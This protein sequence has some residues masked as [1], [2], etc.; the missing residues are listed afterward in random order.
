MS[1]ATLH[2]VLKQIDVVLEQ[3]LSPRDRGQ[4]LYARAT[5]RQHLIPWEETATQVKEASELLLEGG[6]TRG[7][8]GAITF[9]AGTTLAL[10][11]ID[12]SMELALRALALGGEESGSMEAPVACNL[13]SILRELGAFRAA[14]NLGRVSIEV[15]PQQ[16]AG[17][18]VVVWFNMAHTALEGLRHATKLTEVERISWFE[19]AKLAAEALRDLNHTDDQGLA[20]SQ[21]VQ[22]EVHLA[23]GDIVAARRCIDIA[24]TTVGDDVNFLDALIYLA[25]GVILRHEDQPAAALARFDQAYEGLAADYLPRVRALQQRSEVAEQLGQFDRA[26]A[27]SRLLAEMALNRQSESSGNLIDQLTR[28]ADLERAQVALVS[29][30][31][32]LIEQVRHDEVTGVA[33]RSWL[34][35]TFDRLSATDD[36]VTLLILDLDSFKSINDRFGHLV[37]DEVLR[38]VGQLLRTCVRADDVAG[39]FG[40]DEF[41]VVIEHAEPAR[42]RDLAE[43]IRTAVENFDWRSIHPELEVTTSV[44]VA[45]GAARDVRAVLERADRNMYA[46]KRLGRNQIHGD[47]VRIHGDGVGETDQAKMR[48]DHP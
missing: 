7:A 43:A 30:T 5:A 20:I 23:A 11:R 26:L 18:N 28:R 45:S 13:G 35:V 46:A 38:H 8:L 15:D 33:S 44:G 29:E 40:G 3:D 41:V 48:L 31:N 47:G 27:D 17:G 16:D 1:S 39:R 22:A 25:D 36:P 14:V 10:G 9:A 37:G 24:L 2:D 12:E 6:D 32:Q 34:E 19:E 4:L 21:S 42:G